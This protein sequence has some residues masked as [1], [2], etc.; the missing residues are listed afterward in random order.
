MLTRPV[1]RRCGNCY[2]VLP[3]NVKL[4]CDAKCEAEWVARVK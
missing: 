2:K 4:F 3:A 1:E